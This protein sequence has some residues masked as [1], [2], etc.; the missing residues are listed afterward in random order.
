MEA[1]LALYCR[2]HHAPTGALCAECDELRDY[3]RARLEKCP[4]ADE[5]PTCQKCP[6]H[7]YKPECREKVREV[8][9]Y[10]GPRLLWRRPILAVRHLLDE[11]KAAPPMPGRASKPNRA[12]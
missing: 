5:K 1:M 3:A 4:F 9:R 2:R 11:R 12:S 8:M 6:V 7:C 10:A